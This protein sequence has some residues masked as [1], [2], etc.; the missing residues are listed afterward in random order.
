MDEARRT[1]LERKRWRFYD[2]SVLLTKE[3]LD[4][5][6]TTDLRNGAR[7]AWVSSRGRGPVERLIGESSDSPWTAEDW[8]A[9]QFCNGCGHLGEAGEKWDACPACGHV[10]PKADDNGGRGYEIAAVRDGAVTVRGLPGLLPRQETASDRLVRMRLDERLPPRD[11]VEVRERTERI[12]GSRPSHL[13]V[14]PRER[15]RRRGS[16]R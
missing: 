11:S 10:E 14:K 5:I 7:V 12:L 1:E 6:F 15:G 8:A 16:S 2:E 13:V 3:Q 4:T 9:H